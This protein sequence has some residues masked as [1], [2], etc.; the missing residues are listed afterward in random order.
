MPIFSSILY[1]PSLISSKVRRFN[2]QLRRLRDL[3]VSVP[4]GDFYI[5]LL[6]TC[7]NPSSLLLDSC[8]HG[9]IN[10][11]FSFEDNHSY[12]FASTLMN[13]DISTYLPG[14]NLVKVD[15]ASMHFGLEVRSPFLDPSLRAWAHSLPSSFHTS[16]PSKSIL[17]LA[18]SD[19]LPASIVSLP[20]KGFAVPLRSWLLGPLAP[21][22]MTFFLLL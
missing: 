9:S 4:Q 1:T 2:D 13:I 7:D 14:D 3:A 8:D 18:L 16:T 6:S 15:R 22:V 20:K 5:K 19:H 21:W 12:N 11:K 10:P 17:R